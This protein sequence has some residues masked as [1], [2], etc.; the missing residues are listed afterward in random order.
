[1]KNKKYYKIINNQVLTNC[2]EELINFS[3]TLLKNDKY[4]EV[5]FKIYE[6]SRSKTS[7]SYLYGWIF[8]RQLMPKLNDAGLGLTDDDGEYH[9]WDMEMLEAAFKYPRFQDEIEGKKC[10]IT[11]N[12][13]PFRKAFHP[14]K[15]SQKD[16]S[17][18]CELIKNY[19]AQKWGVVVEE[20]IHG[21]YAEM[22]NELK[23]GRN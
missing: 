2:V 12:K 13:K 14:S 16:F 10:I 1:M 8:R 17:L 18:Y 19:S 3:N 5:E 22:Y 6:K 4:C 11:I 20:P 15:L 7:N 21:K 23:L 9:D